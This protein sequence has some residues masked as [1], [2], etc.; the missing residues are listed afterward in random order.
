M[1]SFKQDCECKMIKL[2][3][4]CNLFCM[5]L[6]T[7]NVW[8]CVKTC[9]LKTTPSPIDINLSNY[10]KEFIFWSHSLKHREWLT[11]GILQSIFGV[12]SELCDEYQGYSTHIQKKTLAITNN[13]KRKLIWWF[14]FICQWPKGGFHE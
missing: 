12:L 9:L 7:T 6:G 10:E 1:Y 8:I 14:D 5:K 13:L 2:D 3:G 11:V 4:K